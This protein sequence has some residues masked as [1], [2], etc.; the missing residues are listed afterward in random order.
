MIDY[1]PQDNKI[2][3]RDNEDTYNIEIEENEINQ[4]MDD[5]EKELKISIGPDGILGY[6]LDQEEYSA[7]E[8][9]PDNL[10]DNDYQQED[11]PEESDEYPSDPSTSESSD[12]DDSSSES[13]AD[14]QHPTFGG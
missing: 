11:Y 13:D 14:I 1:T 4:A 8:D 3:L 9:E 2:S 6:D 10:F 7:S 5:S 12:T